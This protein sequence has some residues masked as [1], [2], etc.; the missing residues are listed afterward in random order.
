MTVKIYNMISFCFVCFAV[1]VSFFFLPHP[2]PLH[3]FFSVSFFSPLVEL[4]MSSFTFFC[5]FL[6]LLFLLTNYAAAIEVLEAEAAPENTISLQA[7]AEAVTESGATWTASADNGRILS[8]I[9]LASAKQLM[10]VKN[11]DRTSLSP[12]VFTQLENDT[13]IPESFDAALKWPN[14]PSLREIRD[15]SSCGSCWAIAA[16][17]AITDRYCT[18]LHQPNMRI[19]TASLL[20][21]CFVCGLGCNGGWPAAAWLWWV[22][23]GLATEDCQPYPF[24]PCSHHAVSSKYPECPSEMYPTPSCSTSCKNSSEKFELHN[25]AESYSVTGEENYQRELMT[26]GPFEVALTV[27][28]DF[29]TYKSGVYSHT[30]GAQL[31]GH[32]VKLVGWGVQ[33]GVPYWKIANSWNDDWGDQG[34]ILIRR[35]NN[36]CGIE[37]TGVA[38]IP[39]Q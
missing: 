20:S 38:G 7:L 24:P 28:E 23:V 9:T 22:W 34:Y 25:G 2:L 10:G 16:A 1:C 35:G 18:V 30:V 33:N 26:N 12:R 36:E 13:P 5:S 3:F 15:Q 29:L 8:N 37:D 21:C 27:Y 32:A 4:S 6:T 31:G 39:K 17:S 11:F 14:C 19:S